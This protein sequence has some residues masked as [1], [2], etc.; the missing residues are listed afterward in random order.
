V[1]GENFSSVRVIPR[2]QA[3]YSNVSPL[4]L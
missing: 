3:Q 1:P 2:G 4:D